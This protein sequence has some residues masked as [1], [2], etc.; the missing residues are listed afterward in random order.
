MTPSTRTAPETTNQASFLRPAAKANGKFVNPVPT[1]LF[2]LSLALKVLLMYLR[3]REERVPKTS[4]GPFHTNLATYSTAPSSGLRVTWMGHTSMLLEIDG[5]TLLIDPVW[6]KRAS[7]VEWFG[8]KRFFPPPLALRDLPRLDAVLVSHDHY[9]HLGAHTIRH[10]AQSEQARD[11]AWITSLEVDRILR[12]EG[13]PASKIIALNWTETCTVGNHD[14]TRS[15]EITALPARHF[16]GRSLT[17]RFRTLW[18]S[19]VL[20]GAQHRVYFGADSGWWEGFGEIGEQHGPFDLTLLEIGAFHPLWHEI[21]L[22]PEGAAR[23]F[24]ALGAAGLLMPVHWGLFDLA[25]HGW[26][27]PIAQMTTLADERSIRLWSPTPGVPTEIV[28]GEE[29]RSD[30]WRPQAKP[31][32]V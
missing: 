28:A 19:F 6:E 30:W 22:G 20:R 32:A 5:I 15:I 13:V 10:L 8:P 2:G 1:E 18:S 31:S 21:H 9:D 4:L 27:D 7:P 17:N 29:L 14:G 26:R 12:R 3:N 24:E 16:S 25:L 11:A 23:A